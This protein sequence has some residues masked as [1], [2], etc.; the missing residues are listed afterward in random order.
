MIESITNTLQRSYIMENA[1][2]V[3]IDTNGEIYHID[4]D[5]SKEESYTD[6]LKDEDID[7]I[8]LGRDLDMWYS[9]SSSQEVNDRATHIIKHLS[10]KKKS[11]ITIHGNV[12]INKIDNVTGEYMPLSPEDMANIELAENFV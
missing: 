11:S 5:M 4:I 12:F 6:I 7:V 2:V 3:Q 1:Q 8:A 9:T 10:K